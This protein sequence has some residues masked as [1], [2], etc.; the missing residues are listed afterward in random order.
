MWTLHPY[1][2]F[3]TTLSIFNYKIAVNS[4]L[5]LSQ[6]IL[7]IIGFFWVQSCRCMSNR[8]ITL[9]HLPKSV[10]VSQHPSMLKKKGT[11]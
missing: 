4:I 5:R 9:N 8:S 6:P 1:S 3:I 10:D 2:V 11:I 7:F